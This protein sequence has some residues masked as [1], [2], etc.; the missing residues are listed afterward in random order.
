[1]LRGPLIGL[2]LRTPVLSTSPLKTSDRVKVID[3]SL[4][5]A[6]IQATLPISA[7]TRMVPAEQCLH[8]PVAGRAFGTP[9]PFV[10]LL[11]PGTAALD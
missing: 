1:M 5:S 4:R 7:A 10:V 2:R 3:V 9:A 8:L 6:G 11:D